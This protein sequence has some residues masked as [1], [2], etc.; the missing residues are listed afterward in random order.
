MDLIIYRKNSILSILKKD[1]ILHFSHK[2]QWPWY[3]RIL[4]IRR[5]NLDMIW[6][7]LVAIDFQKYLRYYT[8]FGQNLSKITGISYYI[9]IWW[10][11]LNFNLGS[12]AKIPK[13]HSVLLSRV[14]TSDRLVTQIPDFGFWKFHGGKELKDE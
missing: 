14:T 13:V 10:S 4:G 12:H 3:F 9:V 2:S 7:W 8:I 5:E 6:I 1:F 11:E